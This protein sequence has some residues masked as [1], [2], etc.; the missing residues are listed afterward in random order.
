M[1]IGPV[2]TGDV[3]S[4]SGTGMRTLSI[5]SPRNTAR[6]RHRCRRGE[7]TGSVSSERT[8]WRKIPVRFSQGIP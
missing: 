3:G 4:T 7:Y 8:A 1:H 6:G 5:M 2:G